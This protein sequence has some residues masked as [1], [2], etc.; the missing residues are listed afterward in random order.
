MTTPT[1]PLRDALRVA[2]RAAHHALDHHPLLAPLVRDDLDQAGYA[3]ALAALRGPQAAI[4]SALL[5][6]L[7]QSPG[8]FDYRLRRK[9][10]WLDADLA[11]LGHAPDP[12]P[13][14]WVTVTNPAEAMGMLY[15]V[16]GATLGGRFI[17][18]RIRA[19]HAE[20]WPL[21]FFTG[22]GD[23]TDTRWAE[24]W[25]VADATLAPAE[26]PVAAR[27]AA[28]VFEALL[29]HLERCQLSKLS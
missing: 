21:R 26:Y 2:T 20:A 8:L 12:P 24:F 29:R 19:R 7:D 15:T 5:G 10:A 6:Y 14:T 3:R 1:A 11:D 4:E 28:A 16:E 23:Q 27:T 13:A 17:A 9:L 18:G 22:Y 25:R